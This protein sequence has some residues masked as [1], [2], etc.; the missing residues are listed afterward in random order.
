MRLLLIIRQHTVKSYVSYT[1]DREH[2]QCLRKYQS[3]NALEGNSLC[4][5]GF[6]QNTDK[7]SAKKENA[8]FCDYG[9][10]FSYHSY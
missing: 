7:L 3:V 4:S 6:T 5:V 10:T 2:S 1:Y 8:Q 9:V